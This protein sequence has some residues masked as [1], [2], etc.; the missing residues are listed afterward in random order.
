MKKIKICFLGCGNIALKHIKTIKENKFDS[1]S[2]EAFCDIKIEAAEEFANQYNAKSYSDVDQMIKCHDPDVIMVLTP[3]GNHAKD[4][5]N[6]SKYGKTII[7]EK[8]MALS[9]NDA[10]LMINSCKEHDSELFVIK[11]NRYNLPIK[12]LKQA[13]DLK[14]LGDIFMGTIRLRWM[15]DQA[16]FNA[17]N[18]RGTWKHDGGVLAN[19]ASHHI[20]LLRWLLGPVESVFASGNTY[21][22]EIETENSCA[23]TIKFKSGALG[24]IE[25]TT[26]IRPKDMEGSISILGTKGSIEVGGFSANVVNYWEQ[27]EKINESIKMLKNPEEIFAFGHFRLYQELI[28]KFNNKPYNLVTGTEAKE[29]LELIISLYQSME[30]NQ[31][32]FFPLQSNISK[33][34]A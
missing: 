18:W 27:E 3:S 16:Y 9:L 11:Q 5:I 8:P 10:E 21:G 32:I 23:A 20:D 34:G 4:V 14:S 25:A 13:L 15:R 24:I 17:A 12:E 29:S 2:I 26:A 22:V 19:Q 6:I 1:I 33:L 30:L 28:N 7:V 31:Q